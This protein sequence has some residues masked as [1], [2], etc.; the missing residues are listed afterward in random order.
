MQ[1][2][3][4]ILES[5][6]IPTEFHAYKGLPHGFGIGTGTNAESWIYDAVRFWEEQMPYN[7]IPEHRQLAN[8]QYFLLA[9]TTNSHG[10]DYDL[11]DNG[12]WNVFDLCLMRRRYFTQGSDIFSNASRNEPPHIRFDSNFTLLEN[13]ILQFFSACY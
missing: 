3:C 11:D 4:E 9:R 6:G 10:N 2:R 7:N 12:T 8:L 13:G 5:Y 1:N